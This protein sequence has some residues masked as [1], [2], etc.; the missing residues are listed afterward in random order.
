MYLKFDFLK[1]VSGKG[2]KLR[3]KVFL[4]NYA[5]SY[6]KAQTYV[7]I[8]LFFKKTVSVRVL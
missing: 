5:L 2:S 6:V 7:T 8:K 3:G 4:H 1:F